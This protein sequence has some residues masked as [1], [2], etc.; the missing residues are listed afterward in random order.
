MP[1]VKNLGLWVALLPASAA[2]AVGLQ[3]ASFPAATL[4]GPLL[5][6]VVFALGG[7]DLK[8]PR[9]AFAGAQ[10]VVGCMVA[11]SMTPSVLA[12]LAFNWPAILLAILQ[13]IVFGAVVGLGLMRFGTLPGTTAAWGTS[14]GGAVAMT[15][16]AESYGADIRMVGFMQYLRIF[17]VVLTASSV[18]RVISVPTYSAS[19]WAKSECRRYSFMS[20]RQMT[21]LTMQ[22]PKVRMAEPPLNRL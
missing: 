18:A 4:L 9:W 13:V 1:R 2:L 11:M 7:A 3:W 8:L 19:L 22:P 12:T 16:M 14:P 20:K 10:S 15:A 5:A 17:V 6:G 21:A